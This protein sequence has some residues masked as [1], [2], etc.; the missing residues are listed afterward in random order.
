MEFKY[1]IN[2][3][4]P[5][6]SFIFQKLQYKEYSAI[7]AHKYYELNLIASGHGK[8]IVGNN[9]STFE[10]GDLILIGPDLPHGREFVQSGQNKLPECLTLIISETLINSGLTQFQELESI[11]RLFGRAL[12]GVA[13]K[14]NHL[15][16]VAQQMEQLKEMH[17]F[18][19]FIALLKLLKTLTEIE[20][21][22][23]ISLTPELPDSYFKDLDQVK[24]VYEFVMNNL[25]N[26]I[27]L[28]TAAGL[29]NMAPGSFCRFFK[30]RT[31]KSFIQYVK[32]IR[33]SHASRMLSDTELPVAQ[34]C[35]ESGYNNLANFNFYFKSIM[36]LT[37]S[38]YRNNFR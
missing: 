12:R 26:T 30:K 13:F 33:I 38:A 19:S 14:G 23:I 37:P 7:Q 17:D 15:K 24:T 11:Q 3:I 5:G 31:G 20:E 32:D 21:Q 10:N 29:L 35:F 18:E 2:N 25:Q 6:K 22:E 28:D 27:T 16:E 4:P 9:I 34:I 36:K 1:T 8:R